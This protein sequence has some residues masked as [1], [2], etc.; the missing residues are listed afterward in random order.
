MF[1]NST[2][3]LSRYLL[4]LSTTPVLGAILAFCIVTSKFTPPTSFAT[5][6]ISMAKELVSESKFAPLRRLLL[7]REVQKHDMVLAGRAN[8][9]MASY[10]SN[11]E[12]A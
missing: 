5:I 11:A 3:V 10:K 4:S 12:N 6:A 1:Y 2:A 7:V 9:L 8:W